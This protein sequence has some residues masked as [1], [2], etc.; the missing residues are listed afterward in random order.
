MTPEEIVVAYNSG[1]IHAAYI[2]YPYLTEMRKTGSIL[3]TN[4]DCAAWEKMTFRGLIATTSFLER[5]GVTKFLKDYIITMARAN[6]YWYNNTK[7]FTL[8]YAGQ[9]SVSAKI[10]AVIPNG[11]DKDV[12]YHMS[13]LVFPSL[14]CV[15]CL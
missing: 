14:M 3:M 10:A 7:E 8:Y 5:P 13:N 9:E 2:G 15:L 4:A 11:V 6:F 12:L 1:A